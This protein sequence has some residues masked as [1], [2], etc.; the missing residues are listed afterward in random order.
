MILIGQVILSFTPDMM[1]ANLSFQHWCHVSHEETPL[2]IYM[3]AQLVSLETAGYKMSALWNPPSIVN[4]GI[5]APR[6]IT[7]GDIRIYG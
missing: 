5:G 6:P 4:N 2:S 3:R 1:K 7:V